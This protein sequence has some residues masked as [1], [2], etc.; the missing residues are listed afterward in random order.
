MATRNP[1]SA[2]SPLGPDAERPYRVV[3]VEDDRGDAVLVRAA[4][5]EQLPGL[6]LTW[7]TNLPTRED[8]VTD[9]PDC[10]LID[11]GLPGV[12][13]LETLERML[14]VEGDVPVIV[15][16]GLDDTAIGMR[17]VARGAADYLVKGA[18]EGDGLARAIGYA[19]ERHHAEVT[20]AQ[21]RETEF[22]RSENMRLERGLLPRPILTS[23]G[24]TWALRYRPGAGT[25]VLG[26]DFFDMIERDDGTIR[27]VVGDVSGHGP[28]EAAL[29]VCMRIAW[30]TLVLHGIADE[31][32]LP[33][34]DDVLVAERQDGQFC[35]VCDITIDADRRLLRSRLAGHPPPILLGEEA[36]FVANTHRGVPI[37]VRAGTGWKTASVDLPASWG[38]LVF[39][40]GVYEPEL[41][42]GD[43]LELAGLIDLVRGQA[44]PTD[45]TSLHRLL[46]AVEQPH[47]DARHTDD[48]AVF[49]LLVAAS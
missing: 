11:L 10:I 48:L 38:L 9:H 3:L 26:G 29:G 34:L 45:K 4:L 39:T 15:L 40:D 43:R 16:T 1:L 2:P 41:P 36:T 17:A 46:D 13:G 42:S 22:A 24:V 23:P 6:E 21:L 27:L 28:D 14:E 12:Q 20:R 31:D 5:E 18:H 25:S 7:Y 8:L 33:A 49:G 35:T 37:G 44:Q 32:L 30:R 47:L 19:V